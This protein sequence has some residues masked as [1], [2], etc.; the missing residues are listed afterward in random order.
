MY[1]KESIRLKPIRAYLSFIS[2]MYLY[3]NDLHLVEHVSKSA[4]TQQTR[5]IMKWN[6][7]FVENS[8]LPPFRR[9]NEIAPAQ[10]VFWENNSVPLYNNMHIAEDEQSL[11]I[12]T[13]SAMIIYHPKYWAIQHRIMTVIYLVGAFLKLRLKRCIDLVL[14]IYSGN[15][16]HTFAPVILMLNRLI[17]N[18][19]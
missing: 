17:S 6:H 1:I 16:F 10:R 7:C 12:I 14:F 9:S 5:H 8:V 15:V 19:P 11:H 4:G 3:N 2:I 13:T 18:L